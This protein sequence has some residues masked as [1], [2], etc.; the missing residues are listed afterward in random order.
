MDCVSKGV[1]AVVDWNFGVGS[2]MYLLV[3]IRDA[4]VKQKKG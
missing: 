3:S 4:E 1:C 2:E